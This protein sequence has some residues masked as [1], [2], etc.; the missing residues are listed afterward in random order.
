MERSWPISWRQEWPRQEPQGLVFYSQ[1]LPRDA[2]PRHSS[3]LGFRMHVRLKE[4]PRLIHPK[5]IVILAMAILFAQLQCVAGCAGDPCSNDASRTES[6]PPCH[7]H[8]N[9]ADHGSGPCARHVIVSAASLPHSAQFDFVNFSTAE[10]T[11][12]VQTPVLSSMRLFHESLNTSPPLRLDSS[13]D[14]L[15]I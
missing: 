1:T 8:H 14:I 3:T 12:S 13:V 6:V 7:Q 10:F 4:G 11:A 2:S 9:D 15:R 5:F